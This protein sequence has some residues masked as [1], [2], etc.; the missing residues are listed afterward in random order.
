MVR[1]AWNTVQEQK[2]R[3]F[4][5]DTGRLILKL[6]DIL[7]ADFAQ[8]KVGRSA[9]ILRSAM[10]GADGEIFDFEAMSQVL[11]KT[12]AR[13]ALPESRRRRIEDLLKV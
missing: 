9:D 2:A 11:G 8:S 1:Y 13:I 12:A 4:R 10:G 6:S 3:R 7:Q 5:A